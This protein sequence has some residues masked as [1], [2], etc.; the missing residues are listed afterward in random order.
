MPEYCLG[1]IY[2]AA[3]VGVR[4]SKS[5]IQYYFN[6]HILLENSRR[7][8]REFQ[9]STLKSLSPFLAIVERETITTRQ[10]AFV[11]GFQTLRHNGMD[12]KKITSLSKALTE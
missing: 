5:S 12:A 4:D 10:G 3:V 9:A 11:I 2:I 8:R 7:N 6:R 1:V